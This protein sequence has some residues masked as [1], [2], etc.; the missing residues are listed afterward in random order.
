MKK[1]SIF[2]SCLMISI[3]MMAGGKTMPYLHVSGEHVVNSKGDTMYVHG[4]NLGNWLNPEGYMFGFRDGQCNS[5]RLINELVCQM[6]GPSEAKAFWQ[7]YKENYITREDIHYI[8]STGANTV[9][10]PFHYKLFTHEDYLGLNDPEEGFRMLDKAIRWCKQEGLYVVLD[11]HDCPGGQTGDNIDDSYGYPYLFGSEEAQAQFV[12]IWERIARHYKSEPAVLGYEL[13]NEP[14]AHYFE[15]D[16]DSL[17]ARLMPLYSRTMQAIRKIDKRHIILLGGA[18]WN[19]NFKPLP[20]Q[21]GD[22]NVL[23]AC[24][25]YGHG[26]TEEGIRDFIAWRDSTHIAMVMTETGHSTHEWYRT[27]TET[28]RRNNIGIL[29]WPYKKL[30]NSCWMNAK[31]PESWEVVTRFVKA[32]RTTY[33]AIRENRPDVDS[34]RQA[35]REYL[36]AVKYENCTPEE[37]YIEAVDCSR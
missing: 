11:M 10:L 27:E 3:A 18:Q 12:A 1:I 36:E 30:G 23:W 31:M 15:A 13:M 32:D 6:V 16:L 4:V 26:P 34:C 25:R 37:A 29:W 33:K 35:L 28:L 21:V 19:G 14:I 24:H 20:A 2:M 9:R 22:G 17:N 8:A 7:T 5:P